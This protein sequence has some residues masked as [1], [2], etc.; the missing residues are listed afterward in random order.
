LGVEAIEVSTRVYKLALEKNYE[1][2]LLVLKEYD[3]KLG[4]VGIYRSEGK[5]MTGIYRAF[6]YV[7]LPFIADN[8]EEDSRDIIEAACGYLEA[9][10]KRVRRLSLAEKLKDSYK[11][12]IPLGSLIYKV[13][14]ILPID[15]FNKVVWLNKKV[16]VFAKHNYDFGDEKDV[17]EHYFE[18][19]EAVAIY[20]IVRVLGLEIEK[21]GKVTKNEL[22]HS[23]Y[24]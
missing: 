9:L 12:G 16:Y 1:K 2:S 24:P 11:D 7:E 19:D 20:L 22:L 6:F 10:I 15:V 4:G 23:P 14:N 13:K 5:K 21:T 3:A 18:L 17:P 8:A